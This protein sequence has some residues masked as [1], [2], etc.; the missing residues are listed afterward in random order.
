MR[1]QPRRGP[2]EEAARPLGAGPTQGIEP[3]AQAETDSGVAPIAE[4]V[5][6]PDLRCAFPTLLCAP[7]AGQS[8]D[9]A[10]AQLSEERLEHSRRHVG[11]VFE[12]NAEKTRRGE[13]QRITIE[14][15]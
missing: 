2:I 15:R 3:P 14:P 1:Q 4:T 9:I 7:I 8:V 10:D 6:R 12:K 5:A 11:R 13:L